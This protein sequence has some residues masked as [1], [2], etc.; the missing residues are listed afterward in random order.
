MFKSKVNISLILRIYFNKMFD[1][2]NCGNTKFGGNA[3]IK[4]KIS[5]N[6]FSS[7][8]CIGNDYRGI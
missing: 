3:I 4:V 2:L 7:F 1:S 6:Y 8:V 5:N